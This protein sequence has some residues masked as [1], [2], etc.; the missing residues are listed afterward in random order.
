MSEARIFTLYPPYREEGILIEPVTPG[1]EAPWSALSPA[2]RD[3]IAEVRRGLREPFWGT[4]Y[5]VSIPGKLAN[6]VHVNPYLFA[7]SEALR[8]VLV[9]ANV[10][11]V[12][13]HPIR[14][15]GRTTMF[16]LIAPGQVGIHPAPREL[17]LLGGVEIGFY[18]ATLHVSA[19]VA[20]LVQAA[21]LDLEID[22]ATLIPGFS[23]IPA[24]GP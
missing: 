5:A 23:G 3:M 15:D 10:S 17:R 22:P 4:E 16:L 7:A 9:E 12:R 6:L 19:R 1:L 24:T 14:V 21:D 13:Y 18:N 2:Y 11:G 20:R 8:R